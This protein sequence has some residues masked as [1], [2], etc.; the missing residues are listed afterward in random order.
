MIFNISSYELSD[1]EKSILCKGLSF[2]VKPK[3][4]EYSKFLL[5]FEL[6]FRD[7]KQENLWTEDLSLM[8]SRLLDTAL[9]SYESFPGE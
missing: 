1:V 2:L 3:S 4:T 5:P 6:L 7:I 8:K 9:S